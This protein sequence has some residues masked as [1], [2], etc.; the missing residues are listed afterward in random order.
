[1]ENRKLVTNDAGLR[2]IGD[3]YYFVASNGRCAT[4][5]YNCWATKCDLPTGTYEFDAECKM[6]AGPIK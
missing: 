5:E 6:I 3:D 2:K 1:V 4:G